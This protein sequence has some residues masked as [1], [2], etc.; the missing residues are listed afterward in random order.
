[1]ENNY[2]EFF[3]LCDLVVPGSLGDVDSFRKSFYNRE[4][5]IELIKDL[6]LVTKPLVLRRTK[7]Q[8]KLSLPVKTVQRVLLPFS[9][10]QKEIYKR[11]AMRFSKQVEDLVQSQG[12]RKAQIAM[13]AALMRLRQ[14]CSDPAAVPGVEYTETPVKVEHFLSSL[15]EHL[16]NNESVIVFT[17]FLSTLERLSREL[18]KADLEHYLWL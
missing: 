1:M 14:I 18:K 9:P 12:E 8:V 2:L 5:P 15:S 7:E 16:E 13:F 6:K 17:Q 3:S 11:M 4:V 10:Q